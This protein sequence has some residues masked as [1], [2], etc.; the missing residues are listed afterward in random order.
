MAAE[1]QSDRMESD[2]EVHVKERCVTEFLWAE[3]MAPTDIHRCLLSVFGGQ[4]VDVS[5]VRLWMMHHSSGDSN[6]GSN[7]M[8]GKN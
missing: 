8:V 3:N 4:P 6:S 7:K 5:T 2:M 1:G